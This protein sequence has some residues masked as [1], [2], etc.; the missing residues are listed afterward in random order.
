[1]AFNAISRVSPSFVEPR[2][3]TRYNQRSGAFAAL[4]TGGPQVKLG[5][6]DLNVYQLT[7]D[8][9]SQVSHG[10]TPYQTIGGPSF[11]TQ[12]IQ[13]ST[14]IVRSRAEFDHHDTASA[15]GWN[16]SLMDANRKAMRAGIASFA[17]SALLYGVAPSEGEGLLN[18]NG[19]TTLTF[20]ADENGKVSVT[21]MDPAYQAQE[22]LTLIGQLQSRIMAVSQGT[23]RIVILAPQRTIQAW[24]M[25]IVPLM[26]YQRAGGG[27][28][29]I[30]GTIDAVAA[31]G[32]A[33]VFFAV[34]DTLIG[35]GAAGSDMVV[36]CAPEL[37]N[38]QEGPGPESMSTNQF[39]T[40]QNFSDDAT[41]QYFD[42][43][44]PSEIISPMAGGFTDQ[45]LE[46][47]MTAG[48]VKRPEALTLL[49]VPYLEP[50]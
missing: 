24:R 18:A 41:A 16:I 35:K 1:M 50:A 44:A 40:L 45:M 5:S 3:L 21:G 32:G 25:Q 37:V 23:V 9:R 34:D 2:I 22:L 33:D 20:P 29:T 39:A 11:V 12:Q 7:I 13:A 43:A 19:A 42:K 27:T 15:A 14:Y 49:S 36:I 48:W 26:S 17:R 38:P 30:T 6:E 47:R 10:Q 4:G 28:N 31:D 46:L 8:M